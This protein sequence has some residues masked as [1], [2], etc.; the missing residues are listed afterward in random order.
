MTKNIKTKTNTNMPKT[1]TVDEKGNKVDF[2]VEFGLLAGSY[3][4]FPN[5]T[6]LMTP[7]E[8]LG[9]DV[10]KSLDKVVDKS[11]NKSCGNCWGKPKTK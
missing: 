9:Y 3:K 10:K 4:Q 7:S 1:A 2:M 8:H 6:I 11:S 5:R